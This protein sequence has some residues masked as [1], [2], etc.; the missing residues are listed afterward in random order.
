MSKFVQLPDTDEGDYGGVHINSGIP[1]KAFYLTAVGIGGYAWEAPGHI[2]YA[3]LQASI[4][5]HE[6]PGIRRHDARQGRPAL[7]VAEHGAAGRGVRLE[8]SRHPHQRRPALAATTAGCA[9]NPPQ[10]PAMDATTIR[11]R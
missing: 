10:Q 4:A 3:S 6:F 9:T 8:G 2:W 5:R 11:R 7:R 1:N